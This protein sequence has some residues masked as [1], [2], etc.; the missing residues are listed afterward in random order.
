MSHKIHF[1]IDDVIL[2]FKNL[3]EHKD[4]D[5]IPSVKL[6]DWLWA[7]YGIPTS[8][9]CFMRGYGIQLQS[10]P[11]D[12]ALDFQQR[13]HYLKLGFHSI[14]ADTDYSICS[15]ERATHDYEMVINQLLRIS[16]NDEDIISRK[17]R[18]HNYHASSDDVNG[19][20]DA[21]CGIKELLTADDNRL[22]YDLDE[23][24]EYYVNK[25]GIYRNTINGIGYRKTTFRIE[26]C[27]IDQMISDTNK[28]HDIEI[29]THEWALT[30][31]NIE[32]LKAVL[33]Y[34]AVE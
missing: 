29:F 14:D 21:K 31:E 20:R 32:K 7:N 19:F 6:A 5:S 28:Y 30:D 23:T 12:Y 4:F 34:V 25:D 15:T 17:I 18:I 1:S 22:S 9:F 10:V 8:L 2:S 33:S 13:K 24:Q 26:K 11:D 27:D 16:G 3:V